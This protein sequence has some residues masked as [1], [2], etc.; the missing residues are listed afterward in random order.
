MTAPDDRPTDQQDTVDRIRSIIA[1]GFA[2]VRSRE[3]TASV[4]TVTF[5]E[6]VQVAIDEITVDESDIRVSKLTAVRQLKN[7]LI[8][9]IDQVRQLPDDAF[10]RS[11]AQGAANTSVDGSGPSD[12]LEQDGEE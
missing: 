11:P 8:A 4:A 10:A 6:S 5:E 9:A 7:E 1:S 12:V 3:V 2:F